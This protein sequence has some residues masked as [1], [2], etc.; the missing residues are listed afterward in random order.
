MEK[1]SFSR[2]FYIFQK[3]ESLSFVTTILIL[4]IL[5]SFVPALAY[6]TDSRIALFI[7]RDLGLIYFIVFLSFLLI[8]YSSIIYQWLIYGIYQCQQSISPDFR[9]GSIIML[10]IYLAC[11]V[12]NTILFIIVL[13]VKCPNFIQFI[14]QLFLNYYLIPHYLLILSISINLKFILGQKIYK[15]LRTE[16]K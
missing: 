16:E 12:P 13:Y 1:L 11:I 7:Y 15:D 14:L 6:Y 10:I 3:S 8:K 9:K 2:K 4:D 5:C